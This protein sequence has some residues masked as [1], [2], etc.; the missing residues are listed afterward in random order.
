M[1]I[2]TKIKWA[3]L[4]ATLISGYALAAISVTDDDGYTVTL[5]KPAQRVISMAPHVTELL[6]AAGGGE[7]IVGAVTYSDFP[8]AAKKIPSIGDNREVDIER[9]IASKP[10]LLVVWRHGSSGKQVE[11]LRKLGIP[12]FYSEPHVLADIP[13]SVILLGKLMGTEAQANSTALSLQQKLTALTEK[14]AKRAPVRLFYQ[15]WDKPL[16][17][18]SGQHIISDAMRICGGVNIFAGMKIVAPVVGVEAVIQADPEAIIGTAEKSPSDGGVAMWQRY[19]GMMAVK[20]GNLFLID[21]NLINRSGPRMIDGTAEL[22]EKL[23]L[24]REHRK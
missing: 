22:C 12:M 19:P 2:M 20:R 18:L 14:Y 13:A 16:Y 3:L 23:D 21:G 15:V 5:A 4:M 17:T 1:K 24:A 9:I 7:H 8:E 11:Q 10:D 6:F